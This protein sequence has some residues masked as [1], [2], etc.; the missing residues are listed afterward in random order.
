MH[1]DNFEHSIKQALKDR[2]VVPSLE[3]RDKLKE[4]L[5]KSENKKT[6]NQVW[7]WFVAA[8]AV[9]GLFFVAGINMMDDS[10]IIIEPKVVIEEEKGESIESKIIP[11]TNKDE[12]TNHEV[13][14]QSLN[15][16]ESSAEQKSHSYRLET[17][18]VDESVYN[19]KDE[20]EIQSPSEEIKV[21][22]R[23]EN[24]PEEE[25][26]KHLFITPEALLASL[27][28]EDTIIP[29]KTKTPKSSSF[30]ESDKL[31]TK[32]EAQLFE[33]DHNDVFKKVGKQLKRVQETLADR[34]YKD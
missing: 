32:M 34:N 11:T 25:D 7:P 33:E 24:S 26:G 1:Q 31:L 6:S 30:I 4:L 18:M 23:E 3:S 10:K 5:N 2:E 17:T 29:H 16:L 8:T 21:T 14:E 9:I 20:I 22:P 12:L 27:E 15:K 19:P 28:Q 13:V